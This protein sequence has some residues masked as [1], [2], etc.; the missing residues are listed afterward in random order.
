MRKKYDNN[1]LLKKGFSQHKKRR[2]KKVLVENIPG[3][4]SVDEII[5]NNQKKYGA[6]DP[7]SSNCYTQRVRPNLAL[8]KK[9]RASGATV[10]QIRKCF[11]VSHNTFYRYMYNFEE[12]REAMQ[13]GTKDVVT[14]LEK[15]LYQRALGYKVVN[16]KRSY[17]FDDEGNKKLVSSEEVEKTVQSD[18]CLLVALKN[19][20]PEKWCQSMIYEPGNIY[21]KDGAEININ[22]IGEGTSNENE[23]DTSADE[24]KD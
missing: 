6:V 5:I 14:L 13:K 21:A 9:M 18:T 1:T 2:E 19:L 16:E 24:C 22:L 20:D 3:L 10:G 8:I 17:D 15:T 7:Y 23:K 12:L 4:E 11:G